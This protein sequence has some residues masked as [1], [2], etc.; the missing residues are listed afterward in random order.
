MERRLCLVVN[1]LLARVKRRKCL[2]FLVGNAS[3][4]RERDSALYD[5]A[6][7]DDAFAPPHLL[8]SLSKASLFHS[9]TLFVTLC[10]TD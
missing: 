5:F 3:S 4:K 1:E 6:H 8:L 2:K 9:L 7:D 10:H